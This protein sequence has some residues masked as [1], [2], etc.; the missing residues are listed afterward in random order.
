M[1]TISLWSGMLLVSTSYRLQATAE[2]PETVYCMAVKTSTSMEWHSPHMTIKMTFGVMVT[3]HNSGRE[4]GG[5]TLACAH[6]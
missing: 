4:D 5:T 2:L 6:N 1:I 3:V